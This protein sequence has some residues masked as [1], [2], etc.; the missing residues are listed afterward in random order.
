[1][2]ILTIIAAGMTAYHLTQDHSEKYNVEEIIQASS[3]PSLSSPISNSY[4][5]DI[6]N[7]DWSKAGNFVHVSSA[8]DIN[9]VMVTAVGNGGNS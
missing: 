6:N 2:E 1:M 7:I 3:P 4:D 9:W 8:N 5:L